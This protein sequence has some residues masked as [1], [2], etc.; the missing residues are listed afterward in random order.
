GKSKKSFAVKKKF[1]KFFDCDLGVGLGYS[2]MKGNN[3]VV[4]VNN[5]SQNTNH[6]LNLCLRICPS[7]EINKKIKLFASYNFINHSCQTNT[8]DFSK[9]IGS[10]AFK[11]SLSTL[12]FGISFTPDS[13]RYFINRHMNDYKKT[14]RFNSFD[15]SFGNHFAGKTKDLTTKFK[16]TQIS[17]VNIGANHLFPNSRLYGRFDLC[18]DVFKGSNNAVPFNSKYFK[19]TYQAFADMRMLGLLKNK[20]S[21]LN[22]ALGFGLGFATMYNSESSKNASDVFLNGD[23]MYAVVFTA[24]PSYKLSRSTSIILNTSFTS[25]TLQS[26]S[27]DLQEGQVNR[28]FN[29][30][31]MNLSVGMRYYLD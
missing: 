7:Y 6:L 8:F 24:N 3:S 10:T 30:R 16:Q 26:K 15:L 17:H 25:H 28:G 23:D 21:N 29:G 19:L 20:N 5:L 13:K 18:F 12:N 27:W 2:I 4:P 11:G 22:L 14:H 1:I 31:F 9:K